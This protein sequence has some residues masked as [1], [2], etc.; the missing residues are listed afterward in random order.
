M[1]ADV[2]VI[3]VGTM[4]SM[5][6]WQLA[7]QGIS[8]MGFEQFGTGHDRSA[9]GGETRIFRTAYLEGP[10]YVP[11]L[12]ESYNLWLDLEQETG[13]DLLTLNGGLMIGDPDEESMK[14]VIR[15]I[16]TFDLDH[17]ILSGKEA[18]DRFPQ[19]HL[20]P[21]EMM[22]LDKQA[23]FL[24][25]EFAV[26][27]AVH[28]AEELGAVVHRHSQ[29][30]EVNPDTDGVTIY[31]NGKD[32]RVG[33]VIIT[34]GPWAGEL[35]PEVK[36][37]LE[38][39]RI[40]MTWF[41]S[42]NLKQFRADQFPIFIRRSNDLN[43][44]GIPTVDG[45]M[46]KIALNTTYGKVD[47][48]DYL[49]RTVELQDLSVVSGAVRDLIPSLLSDPVRVSAYMD[50]YTSDDHSIVGKVPGYQNTIVLC[51]FSGHGFKMAP[52]MGRIAAELTVDGSTHFSIDHLSPERFSKTDQEA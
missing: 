10:Q 46:V 51:G 29:V 37:Q 23:G 43:F 9:A 45:S 8:V 13:N 22:V 26:V 16:E 39:R 3:G 20:L 35:V 42:M 52:I 2:G 41:P 32:Y 18:K 19:H 49:N 38:V 17:E 11:L 6:M 47:N 24:R 40:V 48:P 31:A 33:K 44:F 4:G 21:N 12:Q 36:Q 14:N 7:K 50:A 34:A 15:S 27:S 25:P 28:R 30:E 1:D 5:A